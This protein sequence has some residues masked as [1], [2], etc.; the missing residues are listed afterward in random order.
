MESMALSS[1][2]QTQHF[3]KAICALI[4]GTPTE[5]VYAEHS[6]KIVIFCT[7]YSKIGSLF[8][9]TKDQVETLDS[10]AEIVY[11]VKQIAGP[12]N[13]E[14]E[15][16]VRFIAEQLDI[17]KKLCIFICLKTYEKEVVR[18]VLDAL[19]NLKNNRIK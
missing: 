17:S 7:Q 12:E 11:S 6:D 5:L 8:S 18:A 19:I 3:Y 14:Q 16:A 4:D 13:I 9:A 1:S 2:S 15:A 10:L